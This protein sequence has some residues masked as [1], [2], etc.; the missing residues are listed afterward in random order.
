MKDGRF[1]SRERL[2]KILICDVGV[3]AGAWAAPP[4]PPKVAWTW[5]RKSLDTVPG[6]RKEESGLGVAASEG[7]GEAL[8]DLRK[9]QAHRPQPPMA[10]RS[11]E[12][13]ST[14]VPWQS[15]E[16]PVL[17]QGRP[18]GSSPPPHS[19]PDSAIPGP[20]V[21]VGGGGHAL[22]LNRG[23]FS[24]VSVKRDGSV[25]STQRTEHNWTSQGVEREGERHREKK[26][27]DKRSKGKNQARHAGCRTAG[28]SSALRSKEHH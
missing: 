3:G 16:P 1:Y 4:V 12:S 21:D 24:V 10:F 26:G 13:S 9:G 17:P 11:S 7:L 14:P 28:M 25:R 19:L 6:E 23:K 27:T 15:L 5:V 18:W 2:P 8:G 22:K 20:L